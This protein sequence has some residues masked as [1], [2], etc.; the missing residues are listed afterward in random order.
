MAAVQ[1][2]AICVLL[3]LGTKS[4]IKAQRRYKTQYGEDPLSDNA[5]R[6]L[7]KQF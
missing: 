5:V 4:V 7:L 6:F 2:T 1:Q 3:F